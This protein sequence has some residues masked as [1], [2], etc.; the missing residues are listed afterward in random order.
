MR[1][2]DLRRW[3]TT[4][5]SLNVDVHGA[6]ILRIGEGD[7]EYDLNHVVETRSFRSAYLPI[8]YKEMLNVSGLVQNEGWE[9][10]Q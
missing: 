1:F 7:Y 3:S 6:E 10:W 9:S 4:L 2:F 8:P 5:G